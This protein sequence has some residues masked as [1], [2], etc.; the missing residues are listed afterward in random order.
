M[1]VSE[2]KTWVCICMIGTQGPLYPDC[3]LDHGCPVYGSWLS[4]IRV[5]NAPSEMLHVL[6]RQLSSMT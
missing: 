4:G 2:K 3:V 1:Y 5:K 6:G